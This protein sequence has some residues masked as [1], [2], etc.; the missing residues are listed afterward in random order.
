[1]EESEKFQKLISRIKQFCQDRN[2]SQ[3]HD[4]KNL[5]ISLNLEASEVLELFQWTKD[6]Q[7]KPERA[8]KINE[9]LAD[10]FYWIIML[11]NHYDIDLVSALNKKMDQN[12][13]KYPIEKAKGNSA[14]YNEL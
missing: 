7:L 14:K 1:M 6:N 5:A 8:D 13:E 9:E 4:P 11:S 10:V 12:E 3:F 2:W